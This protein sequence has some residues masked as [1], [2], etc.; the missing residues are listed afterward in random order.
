MKFNQDRVSKLDAQVKQAVTNM[1]ET[2]ALPAGRDR[3]AGGFRVPVVR[4]DLED[5]GVA[6]LRYN[7]QK[8]V[9]R[10]T[11]ERPD[12]EPVVLEAPTATELTN[13][14]MAGHAEVELERQAIERENA[15]IDAGLPE[16]FYEWEEGTEETGREVVNWQQNYI[17]GQRYAD[18]L[19]YLSPEDKNSLYLS[20]RGKLG[21]LKL[22]MTAMNLDSAHADLY[23]TNDDYYS[24]FVKADTEK[25]RQIDEASAIEA[26]EAEEA[27]K[28]R[29]FAEPASPYAQPFVPGQQRAMRRYGVDAELTT[30]QQRHARRKGM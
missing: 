7:K 23:D 30:R 4:I 27:R 26:I 3:I 18:A 21:N 1:V 8:A 29:T 5:G 16:G 6:T 14:L 17:Y 13:A 12:S 28:D 24:L 19:K 22:P 15:R 11:V 25:Q 2:G 9:Y 10:M 20:I